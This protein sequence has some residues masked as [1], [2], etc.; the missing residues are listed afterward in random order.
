MYIEWD[1]HI[2]HKIFISFVC[3]GFICIILAKEFC[4]CLQCWRLF[5]KFFF[6]IREFFTSGAVFLPPLI[7]LLIMFIIPLSCY[8]T[9]ALYPAVY[10][11]NWA[12]LIRY[13][14]MLTKQKGFKQAIKQRAV[15]S[16]LWVDKTKSLL[17]IFRS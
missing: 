7:T 6:I 16:S 9:D 4:L 11:N 14:K 5:H 13:L 12:K 3:H 17:R 1:C 8:V 10:L 2:L 15:N